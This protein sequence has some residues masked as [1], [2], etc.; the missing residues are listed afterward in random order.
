MP[1]IE[2]TAPIDKDRQ[3]ILQLPETVPPGE[4]RVVV[5]IE[6]QA[7]KEGSQTRWE[8]NV[9]VFNGTIEGKFEDLLRQ[10]REERI[11]QFLPPEPQ[12]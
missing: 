9:L 5:T 12:P 7:A 2:A 4:H 6:E 1:R 3:L 10:V 8:G 11:Q